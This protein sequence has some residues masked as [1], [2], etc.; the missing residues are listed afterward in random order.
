MKARIEFPAHPG[1]QLAQEFQPEAGQPDILRRRELLADAR[2]RQRRRRSREGG[3]PLDHADG[4]GEAFDSL[5]KVG[6]CGPDRRAPHDCHIKMHIFA[7]GRGAFCRDSRGRGSEL[8][9]WRPKCR[10]LEETLA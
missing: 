7:H 2:G 6:N 4:T 10:S 3:I 8:F 1:G 5:Q 9:A